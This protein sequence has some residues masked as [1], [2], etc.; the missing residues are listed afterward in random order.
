MLHWRVLLFAFIV[1]GIC[2]GCA[3][4]EK[5]SARA[6]GAS[7]AAT[8]PY[9]PTL[10]MNFTPPPGWEMETPREGKQSTTLVWKSP[11]GQTAFGAIRFTLPLPVGHEWAL[12]GFLQNMKKS[13]GRADLIEKRWDASLGA[14]RFIA[15]GG[16]YQVRANLFVQ[17]TRGWAV[18]AGTLAGQPVNETELRQAEA[19]RDAT[20]VP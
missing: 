3:S 18:F 12:W 19:T 4:K 13:E 6:T 17:G 2:G 10:Q 16:R 1:L 14:L 15:E 11:T 5:G 9:H 8:Q 20:A 7:P